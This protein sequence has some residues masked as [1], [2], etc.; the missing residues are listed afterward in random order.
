MGMPEP[1]HVLVTRHLPL[2]RRIAW[3]RVCQMAA[4]LGQQFPDFEQVL[5]DLQQEAALG[6][7]EA[8][9]T[10]DPERG[11]PFAAFAR[12][13][14]IGRVFKE[15][16]RQQR[17]YEERSSYGKLLERSRDLNPEGDSD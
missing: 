6:L 4:A 17:H 8:A 11:R 5:S 3:D 1:R 7:V 12:K 2:A 9:A 10:F 16:K 14:V 13:H 15:A